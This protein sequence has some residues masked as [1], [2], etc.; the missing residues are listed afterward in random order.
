MTTKNVHLTIRTVKP[1]RNRVSTPMRSAKG[2]I[3]L[4]LEVLVASTFRKHLAVAVAVETYFLS[5]LV[6][7]QVAA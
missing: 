2:A 5:Y 7:P 4:E 6:R 3:R 1:Q